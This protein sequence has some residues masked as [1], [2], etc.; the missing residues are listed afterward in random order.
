[1]QFF[2]VALNWLSFSYFILLACGKEK[3]FLKYIL[4]KAIVNQFKMKSIISLS[5]IST[6]LLSLS[7]SNMLIAQNAS[8]TAEQFEKSYMFKIEL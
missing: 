6:L 3:L 1:V 4:L 7:L 5:T 2:Q 8:E